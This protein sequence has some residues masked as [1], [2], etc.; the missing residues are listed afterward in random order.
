V[1]PGI[2]KL[3]V[4][5]LIASAFI[6]DRVRR[7]TWKYACKENFDLVDF[8]LALVVRRLLIFFLAGPKNF[9]C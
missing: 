3:L 1:L 5:P 4:L 6:V 2:E 7:R 8:A 9:G